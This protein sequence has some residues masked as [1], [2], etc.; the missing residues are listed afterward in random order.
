MSTLPRTRTVRSCAAFGAFVITLLVSPL[1]AGVAAAADGGSGTEWWPGIA[2]GI[3]AAAALGFALWPA[4]RRAR[5]GEGEPSPPST[6]DGR[7]RA[8][9]APAPNTATT[10]GDDLRAMVAESRAQLA[11]IASSA[12]QKEAR[13]LEQVAARQIQALRSST[14][15][16]RAELER[17]AG[18][19]QTKLEATATGAGDAVAA[20]AGRPPATAPS[21]TEGLRLATEAFERLRR[22]QRHSIEELDQ[23]RQEAL[24]A[25]AS[26][27][28]DIERAAAEQGIALE[29]AAE[30]HLAALD[31]TGTRWLA[32]IEKAAK[33]AGG[34]RRRVSPPVVGIAV[35]V[36]VAVGAVAL[37]VG[38]DNQR[39]N[40]GP[41]LR[42]ASGEEEPPSTTTPVTTIPAAAAPVDT[43]D[44]ATTVPVTAPDTTSPP[45][46]AAPQPR[47][48][49]S[50]PAPSPPPTVNT[51][52]TTPAA[53]VVPPITF[54]RLSGQVCVFV[55]ALC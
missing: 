22:I 8:P 5:R 39:S 44:T 24:N 43:E 17:T 45:A 30:Q 42:A 4:W 13:A 55:P 47:T 7:E 41:Q 16:A 6:T 12:G 25:L 35:A 46:T 29:A 48:V 52:P 37:A 23:A 20:P 3:G 2:T 10:A 15:A 27:R 19:W 36:A 1:Y 33:Q 51:G 18:E 9:S 54:P 53:P 28:D 49:P 32:R 40:A 21:S 50:Q 31:Q 14:A 26:A 38:G 34:P 11:H